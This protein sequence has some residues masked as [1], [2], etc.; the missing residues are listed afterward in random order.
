MQ[1]LYFGLYIQVTLNWFNILHFMKQQLCNYGMDLYKWIV[2]ILEHDAIVQCNKSRI[3]P[4]K[5]LTQDRVIDP[6]V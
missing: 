4:K 3:E 6:L 1:I 2:H 5:A